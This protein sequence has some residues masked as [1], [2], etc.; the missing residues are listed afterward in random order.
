MRNAIIIFCLMLCLGFFG[1]AKK[2][3]IK[4]DPTPAP[5]FSLPSDVLFEENSA[6]L[7]AEKIKELDELASY[8]LEHPNYIIEIGGHS[9]KRKTS[10][11]K[12]NDELSLERAEAV[13]AYLLKKGVLHTKIAVKGYGFSKPVEE[14][15]PEKGN[16]ANRRVTFKQIK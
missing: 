8:M 5:V 2:E 7:K 16:S 3:I 11:K 13:K 6:E 4:P 14:N 1:C 10:K 12:Y 15:H 9:D